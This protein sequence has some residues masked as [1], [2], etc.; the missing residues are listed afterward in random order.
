MTTGREKSAK[1]QA[2]RI[3]LP[4]P[5]KTGLMSLEDSISQRRSV[6]KFSGQPLTEQQIGQLLWAAQGITH[7]DGFRTAP[8]AGALYALE[9]YVATLTG[10]Y[11]YSPET[12]CLERKSAEDLRPALYR[13]AWEQEPIL[14]AGA[15][16]VITAVYARLAEKYGEARSPR[17]AHLE[18][19]HAAQNVL[20]QA[21]SLGLGS[22]PMGAFRDEQVHRALSLPAEQTPLYL[23]PVGVRS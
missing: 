19:G 10:F 4:S 23:I 20:L 12:H 6:R 11:H 13:A 17:Y 2:M 3:L 7:P 1:P 9:V 5:A 14:A 8:S 18:A 22:V 21:V 15:V 16:F